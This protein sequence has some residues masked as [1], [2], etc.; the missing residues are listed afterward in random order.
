MYPR[1]RFLRLLACGAS[2]VCTSWTGQAEPALTPAQAL[3]YVRVG[4]L[5]FS[6]GGSKLAYV[7]L[8]YRW[9]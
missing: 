9:D 4:D 5:H 3:S 1:A 2:L 8:S 7:A 6:P